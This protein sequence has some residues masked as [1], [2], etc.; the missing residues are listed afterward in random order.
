MKK[1]TTGVR[2]KRSLAV[3]MVTVMMMAAMTCIGYAATGGKI[4]DEAKVWIGEKVFKVKVVEDSSNTKDS[5]VKVIID[6]VAE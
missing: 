4:F 3:L 5:E 2:C 1:R 6:E